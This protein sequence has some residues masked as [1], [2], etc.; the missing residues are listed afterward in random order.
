V[1]DV[2]LEAS[3]V[4]RTYD[5][6]RWADLVAAVGSVRRQTVRPG[7]IVVVV[8]HNPA[9]L[10]RARQALPEAVVVENGD[11][12]GASGGMN[13]GIAAARGD[14]VA[15]LDDDAV[16]EPDWLRELLRPYADPGVLGVGG[17][18]VPAWAGRRPA[19]FPEE[20]DW[21]VGCTFP[22]GFDAPG[23]VRSLI[24]ANMSFRRS[25][26]DHM[27]WFRTGVG[28]VGDTLRK[29]ED[30]EF[31][32]RVRQTWPEAVLYYQPRAVVRHRVGPERATWRYF[33]ARCFAEGQAKA[34]V[35]RLVGAG[36]ALATERTYTLRTLPR[37][38]GRHLG[39]AARHAGGPG[40]LRAGAIVA[41][42]TLTVAGYVAGEAM[43]RARPE[44]EPAASPRAFRWH[45]EPPG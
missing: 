14:V 28:A 31:S 20:F 23:A 42:L 25:I 22:G 3:V 38:L 37:A 43:H 16:A 39:D 44:H 45:A 36:G 21:V 41:G 1:G 12:P 15:F 24:G 6:G 34:Q 19:W 17:R 29:C 35:R 8:D 32:I 27:P 30:T 9:L 33:R 26:F 10:E 5:P 7:E 11:A 13:S 18:I 2:T 4:V 40:A